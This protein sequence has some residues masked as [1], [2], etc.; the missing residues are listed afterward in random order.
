VAGASSVARE[1]LGGY[2][3]AT[4]RYVAEQP[5][6]SA[7]IAAAVGAAVAAVVMVLRSQRRGRNTY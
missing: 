1:R 7:M 5:L 6:K 3:N 4:T 2:A